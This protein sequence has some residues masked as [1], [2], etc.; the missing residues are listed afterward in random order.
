M[1]RAPQNEYT[2]AL[3]DEERMRL[4]TDIFLNQAI[5]VYQSWAEKHSYRHIVHFSSDLPATWRTHLEDAARRYPILQLDEVTDRVKADQIMKTDVLAQPDETDLVVRFRVDDDD[6]LAADYLDRVDQLV[7]PEHFGY[8]VSFGLGIAALHDGRSHSDFRVMR[9]ILPSAGQA[10]IGRF[11]RSTNGLEGV[12]LGPHD[13]IDTTR[14]VI[15]DS[16]EPMY[17]QTYH[18]NQDKAFGKDDDPL[19]RHRK[20]PTLEDE[21]VLATKFPTVAS[22]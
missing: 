21:S 13:R 6:I 12:S 16:Q 4:R 9:Q 14:P 8:A 15:F 2:S 19:I 20:H 17:L 11:N 22:R 7:I 18:D 1:S 5:P 10:Y 3:F